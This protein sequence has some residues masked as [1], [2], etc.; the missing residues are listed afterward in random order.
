MSLKSDHSRT[1]ESSRTTFVVLSSAYFTE[2]NVFTVP[3]GCTCVGIRLAL[4]LNST[5]LCRGH[6][7]DCD[8]V[9]SAFGRRGWRCCERGGADVSLHLCFQL[10][11]ENP[12]IGVADHMGILCNFLWSGMLFPRAAPVC[13]PSSMRKLPVS[14][15]PCHEFFFKS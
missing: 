4:K 15:H 5:A 7:G 3:P 9:A 1:S 8:T 2:H 14:S 10:L 11:W 12:R 13:L 6:S